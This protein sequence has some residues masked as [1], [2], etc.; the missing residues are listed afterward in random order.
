MRSSLTTSFP[1]QGAI[2]F[3]MKDI[4]SEQTDRSAQGEGGL[5][6]PLSGH[7]FLLPVESAQIS[8]DRRGLKIRFRSYVE[9]APSLQSAETVAPADFAGVQYHLLGE[10]HGRRAAK[11]GTSAGGSYRLYG[12]YETG[13]SPLGAA[14]F[15]SDC[16]VGNW[17][18]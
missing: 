13:R 10:G 14:T 15:L 2:Q 4:L 16:F 9:A 18:F 17:I 3:Y 5:K 1:S 7:L 11:S 6:V 8:P 12:L